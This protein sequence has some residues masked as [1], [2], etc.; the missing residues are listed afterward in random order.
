V[1]EPNQAYAQE[2]VTIRVQNFGNGMTPALPPF[3]NDP[4]AVVFSQ[5]LYSQ[6][7]GGRQMRFGYSRMDTLKADTG[8]IASM[9]WFRPRID[10]GI[11]VY[12][13]S[14]KWF[15]NAVGIPRGTFAYGPSFNWDDYFN[16]YRQV[17]PYPSGDSVY[18]GGDSVIGANSYFTRD[19]QLGDS[20]NIGGETFPVK[21]VK[22]DRKLLIT[23]TWGSTGYVSS[24]NLRRIYP[25]NFVP[26]MKQSG[27]YL[28]TGTAASD[29]QVIY[30]KNGTNYIRHLGI[31]DS[32][33]IDSI[34]FK[35]PATVT[36][37][38]S[39]PR[40][41]WDTIYSR[42]YYKEFQIV[43]R[44]K[45]GQ[46]LTDQWVE[47][48][49]E[50][51][52][53]Y[54][55]RIGYEDKTA[56]YQISGNTDTSIFLMAWYLD[57]TGAPGSEWSDTSYFGIAQDQSDFPTAGSVDGG[58]AYIYCAAGLSDI[59]VHD[60]ATGTVNIRG[61]G[62]MF[63]TI[64]ATPPID[65]TVFYKGMH[66]IHFTGEDVAFDQYSDSSSKLISSYTRYLPPGEAP[67]KQDTAG[68]TSVTN[69]TVWKCKT[70]RYSTYEQALEKCEAEDIVE[71]VEW[72]FVRK[73][74]DQLTK[75]AQAIGNSYFPVRFMSKKGD[76]L[77]FV[78]G[79]G[80][81]LT[82][83]VDVS[84]KNW[85]IIRVGM[86]QWAGL[87]EWGTPPQLVAWGDT[88]SGSLLSFSGVNDP[89]N[90]SANNDVLVGNNPSDPIIAM[91]GYDDQL[92]GFRR[93]S[94]FAYD[95]SDFRE[96]S[97]T[98][99]IVGPRAVVGLTKELY[100]Q[101][102]DG[103]KRMARRDF[104]GYSIEKISMDIDPSVNSWS[105]VQFGADVVPFVFNNAYRP[106][107]VFSFNKR[108]NHLYLF[109]TFGSATENNACL[110]YSLD[111]SIWDGYHTIKASDALYANVRDTAR[112]VI[113]SPDSAVLFGLGYTYT[114]AGTKINGDL[115]SAKFFVADQGGFAF[116]S[117]LVSA[118]VVS[119]FPSGAMDSV[120]VI[121]IGGV[122]SDTFD[123]GA[124]SAY[125]DTTY[126]SSTDNISTY[127]QWQIKTWGSASAS[128]F[129]PHELVM[130]FL[131]VTKDDE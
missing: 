111:R 11:L 97:Q 69:R 89:W 34:Y 80:T 46:W 101:D 45:P 123:L 90:W 1:V 54:Y 19:V 94:M 3:R 66:F 16:A 2:P 23:G 86:P 76:T 18:R 115:K 109:G 43:S 10:S 125:K 21:F 35:Y 102:V 13:A 130:T 62:A 53:A 77:F 39:V 84:T 59:V 49:N 106:N 126:F 72:K 67:T 55:V 82:N 20:I 118:R 40:R 7:L 92:V 87:T 32:I 4:E 110:T 112:I 36:L 85:E 27:D 64:D 105:A 71:E 58:F 131:P 88:A 104:S 17:R 95:G 57:T 117:K 121:L 78:T 44:R 47:A 63:W 108:D 5:N 50:N 70:R 100:W 128:V 129:Q 81:D 119:K 48:V 12:A 122:V 51:P 14:R 93:S 38:D 37:W 28:Y 6:N 61:R 113:A 42:E 33:F 9:A 26:Y 8:G 99:G 24:Y 22:H 96:I 127:W 73:K 60:T 114:D 91:V 103:V 79:V 29:P 116:V 65:S 31:V 74:T 83:K 107:T 15:G 56:F 120:Y 98:D 30:F 68:A 124:A 52:E 25:A 41:S 75:E